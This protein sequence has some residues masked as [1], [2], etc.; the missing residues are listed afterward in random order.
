MYFLF[1]L[2][3]LICIT[4]SLHILKFLIAIHKSLW[5]GEH[6]SSPV[7]IYQ[8][9]KYDFN[10]QVTGNSKNCGLRA[11]SAQK[12]FCISL[13][14]LRVLWPMK[15]SEYNKGFFVGIQEKLFR[16]AAVQQD[17]Q[18]EIQGRFQK[19]KERMAHGSDWIRACMNG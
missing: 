13:S 15:I 2:E 4:L 18:H 19:K 3:E 12:S 7:K 5:I 8:L 10:M 16:A 6:F 17:K 11:A 14:P 9:T 1:V